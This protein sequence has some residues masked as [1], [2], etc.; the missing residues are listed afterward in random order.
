MRR[1]SFILLTL[2]SQA[3]AYQVSFEGN[4]PEEVF[5]TATAI[6]QLESECDR[7]PPTLFTLKKRA[8]GDKKTLLQVIHAFGYYE[9]GIEIDYFGVF[10]DTTVRIF[11]KPGPVYTFDSLCILDE[12]GDPLCIDTSE[13]AVQIGCPARSDMILDAQDQ[14]LEKIACW[15]YPLSSIVDREVIVD[16]ESKRVSVTYVVHPGPIAYFGPL[17]IEGLCK[18]RRGYINRRILWSEGELY[19]PNQ[20][21][22]TNAYLQ[23][24]GLFS[25]VTVHPS[26]TV[27]EEGDLPMLIRVEEKKYRHIGAGV[28]YSTDESAG[29]MAQ[30]SHDNFSGWGDTLSLSG[31]YSKIIKRATLLYGMPDFF[32]KDRDLLYSAEVRREDTVGFTERELSFLLRISEKIND[33][34]SFNY[35]GRYERL[36]STKS[37]ND[38]NYHL[39]SAPIQVRWDTS[40]RLLNPTRGITIAYFGTPYKAVL[41]SHI[42]FFRQELFAAT[43]HPILPSGSILL[44]LSGQLGSIVG[45]SRFSIPAPKRFY[46]GSSTGLRGYK[47]LSVSPLSGKKPIGGRSLIIGSVEPR[48]RIL[49][50]LYL[51]T[52]YDIGN[53]YDSSFP[54]L[55]KKLL[56]STGVGI[57][58]LT[59][60]GPFRL[61]IGFPLDKR[62][63][64]DKTFQIYASLG[65]TF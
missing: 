41:N 51:A 8:E 25:I 27:D 58:Y 49:D 35:G 60:L 42:S 32:R 59:P 33:C 10:P 64:I 38:S 22:C 46:A 54:R 63:G 30:W 11:F 29:V 16:Q 28:S 19:N 65:Q 50:K 45:Q 57:R 34:F 36:L 7:P 31:E 37:D 61:D 47:Y 52:F 4:L 39:L 53:V 44:A 24:S 43:Y 3:F 6:S 2:F 56:R 18:V 23:E 13:L 40:N 15:G 9:G 48:F 17:E 55:N 5:E 1:F 12:E 21:S 20:V 26:D 14:I 62:K